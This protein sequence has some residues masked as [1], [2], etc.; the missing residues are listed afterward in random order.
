MRDVVKSGNHRAVPYTT[1]T[2]SSSKAMH[3][4]YLIHEFMLRHIHRDGQ[5]VV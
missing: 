1:I 5:I 4:G 3:A 2:S